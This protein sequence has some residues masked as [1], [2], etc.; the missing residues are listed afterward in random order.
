[1]LKLHFKR[2]NKKLNEEIA[3]WFKKAYPTDPCA[4]AV[5]R[6]KTFYDLLEYEI[7]GEDDAA[8]EIVGPLDTVCRDWIYEEL[9][10]RLGRDEGSLGTSHTKP[11]TRQE[12]ENFL[13]QINRA[14]D[15]LRAAAHG[16]FYLNR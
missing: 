1:M 11:G 16:L 2:E 14:A 3:A 15:G 4:S 8:W 10:K 5:P 13:N 7:N 6:G 9:Y 12:V